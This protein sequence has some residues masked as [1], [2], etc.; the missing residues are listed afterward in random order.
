MPFTFSHPAAVV[1]F[2]RWGFVPSALIIGSMTPD[3]IYFIRMLIKIP[4]GPYFGHTL[5]GIFLFCLPSGLAVLWVFHIILKR[6]LF[7]L[8][9]VSHQ[10]R[11][12]PVAK[13]FKFRPLKQFALIIVSLLLGTFTHIIW[14]SFTHSYGYVTGLLPFL[15]FPIIETDHYIIKVYHILQHG[16]TVAGIFL[17]CFWHIKWFKRAPKHMI[18]STSQLQKTVKFAIVLIIVSGAFILA[19]ASVSIISVNNVYSLIDLVE[20][21]ISAGISAVFIELMIYAFLWHL[22]LLNKKSAISQ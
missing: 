14:D 10:K 12:F 17:L 2:H 21:V 9:P 6:P 8:F 15:R 20:R 19:Y 4:V 1:P 18:N 22:F 11:L 5:P 16:S 13:S 3:F 7:S